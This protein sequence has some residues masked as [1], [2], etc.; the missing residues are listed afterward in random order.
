MIDKAQ[1]S[2]Q[3][4]NVMATID[5]FMAVT[6]EYADKTTKYNMPK[7]YGGMYLYR[8]GSFSDPQAEYMEDLRKNMENFKNYVAKFIHEHPEIPVSAE[9]YYLDG[10]YS[11]PKE[12]HNPYDLKIVADF[13][14]KKSEIAAIK[15][16]TGDYRNIPTIKMTFGKKTLYEDRF[17]KKYEEEETEKRIAKSTASIQGRIHK[18]GD[19]LNS[20]PTRK[21]SKITIVSK[22]LNWLSEIRD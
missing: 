4:R 14:N 9:D 5:S 15:V 3:Q 21:I 20:S 8:N 10:G 16:T 1:I 18:D 22:F 2:A 11:D 13:P 12:H 7:I 6:D 17:G 19:I